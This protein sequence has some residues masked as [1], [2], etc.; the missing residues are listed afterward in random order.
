MGKDARVRRM[1]RDRRRMAIALGRSMGESTHH[2]AISL[3]IMA[4][5]VGG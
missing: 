3:A 2:T 5:A 4:N 1:Q